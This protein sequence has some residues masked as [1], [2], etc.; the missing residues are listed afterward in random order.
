[1]ARL[2]RSEN[3]ARIRSRDT[4]PEM[5][6]RRALWHS[7]LRYRLRYDLPGRPDLVAV[8]KRLAIFVDGCFWHGCPIH[9]SAPTRSAEK[10]AAKLR[11]NVERDLIVNDQLAELGWSVLRV[12]Q[13]QLQK[14]DIVVDRIRA[15]GNRGLYERERTIESRV[16]EQRTEEYGESVPEVPW[17]RCSC[18]CE[19]TRVLSVSE[20]GSLR[21][22]AVKR[23]RSA[24]L[25]CI[26]CRH[27]C[28]VPV[29]GKGPC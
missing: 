3:M 20:P 24:V 10:W 7:G 11:R 8:K 18:G 5:L 9:Y 13:H 16:S 28:E 27:I 12:W 14:I 26:G 6:L 2:S 25:V 23:P 17:Y 4:Q 29:P 22:K 15:L 19:D 1:M 21:P